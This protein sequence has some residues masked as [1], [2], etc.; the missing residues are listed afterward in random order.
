MDNDINVADEYW[1][2]YPDEKLGA[3]LKNK[4]DHFFERMRTAGLMRKIYR[5]RRAV[6]GLARFGEGHDASEL[7][8]DGEQGEITRL[9]INH[10]E[11]IAKHM[12]SLTIND[13]PAWKPIPTNTDVTSEVQTR[14]AEG[15]L[16]YYM[17]ERKLDNKIKDSVWN[18]IWSSL[19]AIQLEWDATAGDP[20]MMDPETGKV[21]KDGDL[22][23][24]V[25]GV[26]DVIIDTA[27]KSRDGHIWR[28]TRTWKNRYDLMAQY[29]EFAQKIRG[30]SSTDW[31]VGST[32]DRD[33]V[34]ELNSQSDDVP[35]Y[36]FWH[37]K[38]EA[39]PEGKRVLFLA[40]DI[41]LMSTPLPYEMIPVYEVAAEFIPNTPFA[42]SGMWT[43]LAI[44]EV[45]DNLYSVISTNQL[46]FG[47]Q[48]ILV[49]ND[50]GI[51]IQQLAGGLNAIKYN[52]SNGFKPE[53]LQLTATPQE[54]F[55]FIRQLEQAMET[56][57]GINGV[58]RGNTDNV[59]KDSSSGAQL[60]LLQAQAQQ[61]I[62]NLVNAYTSMM[63]SIGTGI[64]SILK[65][66][67][68]APRMVQIVGKSKQYGLKEFSG[69]DFE[70]IN[71]VKVEVVS[72]F[73][74][75]TAGKLQIADSLLQ[76]G[77]ITPDKYV[78]LLQ[79]GQM[80]F[81]LEDQDTE[82]INI[83]M[84]NEM[85]AIGEH[86]IVSPLDNHQRHAQLHRAVIDNPDARKRPEVMQAVREHI[87][88]H[89]QASQTTDPMLLQF[90]GQQPVPQSAPPGVPVP[91]NP[92]AG[93][94][95]GQDPNAGLPSPSGMP[96]MPTNPATGERAPTVPGQNL[97]E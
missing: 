52:A 70:G 81:I 28:I 77:A 38:T 86:P 33:A 48:N 92:Q 95:M 63:E 10:Y 15:V 91:G 76:K 40:S 57:T 83:R 97:P 9:R 54:I 30:V 93:P 49:P 12:L 35:V 43:T 78:H 27:K 41:V 80:D 75:T 44:Q 60:A 96:N 55:T 16:D 20:Y 11:N 45:I 47:I 26:L 65:Q 32:A 42:K 39:C 6:S 31:T 46:T 82:M 25:L 50:A 58:I 56:L 69:A 18:A 22:Q 1:A 73:A 29:P 79:T 14:L 17:R 53:P 2:N 59:L 34:D 68:Q 21:L 19:G 8:L 71:R 87:L 5:S 85:L 94:M 89:L 7:G 4:I 37:E 90:L 84:E 61:F 67:A 88:M 24:S 74:K 64:I 62:N 13:R 51:D 72:S 36:T 23:V 3:E 66:Y